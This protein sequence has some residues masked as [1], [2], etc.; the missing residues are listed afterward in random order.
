VTYLLEAIARAGGVRCARIGTLGAAFEG[1]TIEL[2]NTTPLASDLQA[3]LAGFRDH[4]A[5]A[6]AME[7]SSHALDQHRVADIDFAVGAFTNLTRDHLDYH[8][9]MEAYAD[10]KRRLFDRSEVAVINGDDAYGAAWARELRGRRVITY[11]MRADAAVRA[12]RVA[13]GAGGTAFTLDGTAFEL[14]LPGEFNVSNALC[15]I[16]CARE[17][18]ISDA[19]SARALRDFDRVPGRMESF[20]GGGVLAIVDYAHTP[21]ALERVL[22]AARPLGAGDLIAVF[23]CGGDR[24]P[25]K[26][27]RMGEIAARLADRSIVTN[28]NPRHEDPQAIARAILE[29]FGG[30]NVAVEL[31]RRRAIRAAV[32]SARPG[33]VIVVAGKGH[34]TYQ[35]A[36]AVRTE[37]DDREEVRDALA[38]RAAVPA[39]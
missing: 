39:R 1:T 7:V 30:A 16:A 17:L 22:T 36:G 12:E 20:S 28:D 6:V 11:G 29:G 34:E 38:A 9:T 4:G 14:N 10:A 18:G 5:Q 8:G 25:G 2:A 15:A 27:A 3:L 19:I 23:G 13:A 37:F 26:R 31:D 32:E 35:I 21:D 33:D 24:D